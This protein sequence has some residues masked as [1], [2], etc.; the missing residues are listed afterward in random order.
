MVK[1]TAKTKKA[2][3]AAEK[4][5]NEQIAAEMYATYIIMNNATIRETAD[6]FNVP[7]TMV[8]YAIRSPYVPAHLKPIIDDIMK[9]HI[10]TR[11]IRGGESTKKKY[12]AIKASKAASSTA[13]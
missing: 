4:A 10:A 3:S 9:E 5:R 13:P 1:K 6:K 12:A 11:H 8:G 7:K 2:L